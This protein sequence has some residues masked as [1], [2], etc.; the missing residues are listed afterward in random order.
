MMV[1]KIKR[2]YRKKE[3]LSRHFNQLMDTLVF[4]VW[5]IT[6][7]FNLPPEMVQYI[8]S[9]A[10]VQHHDGQCQTRRQIVLA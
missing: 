3:R 2:I 6:R 9:C 7:H 1:D 8:I 10:I 5:L 4:E